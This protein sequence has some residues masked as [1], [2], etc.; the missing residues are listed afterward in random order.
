MPVL[1]N[2]NTWI[3]LY[4]LLLYIAIKKYGKN[5]W[6][7]VLC[8]LATV[9]ITDQLSAHVIKP[10]VQRDRPYL[11]ATFSAQVRLLL[12]NF[13]RGYSFVS[14]HAT[15]H[16][17][18]AIFFIS[19]LPAIKKYKYWFIGWAA[20]VCFAQ[21]YVGLHYP[22]DVLC[23]AVLGIFIGKITAYFFNKNIHKLV[24]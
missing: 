11:D 24:R 16:F 4:V 10:L 5:G 15:N 13:N 14:S 9:L 12:S 6:L 19:T 1:R 23:G 2:V 3:P 8:V 21:V 7:W 22:I 20:F 18:I 17:G